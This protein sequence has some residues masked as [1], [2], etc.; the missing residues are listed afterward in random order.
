M[1]SNRSEEALVPILSV[2]NGYETPSVS[3]RLSS[4]TINSSNY[5]NNDH[6]GQRFARSPTTSCMA[7]IFLTVNAT[8]GA[9]LLNIPHA[10]NDSG[11]IFYALIVQTVR[12]LKYC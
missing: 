12:S 7:A 4:N 5:V 3:T 10:F 6:S 8:L 9:G 11:G 2:G 1:I